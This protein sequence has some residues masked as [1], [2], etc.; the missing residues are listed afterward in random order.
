MQ[1]GFNTHVFVEQSPW[2]FEPRIV[3]TSTQLGD[4]IE[5]VSG[6]KA[7]ERIVVKDGVLLSD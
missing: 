2:Q 7:G 3:K 4:R 5:I 1:S 6:L